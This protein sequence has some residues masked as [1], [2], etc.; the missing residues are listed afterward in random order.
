MRS[1]SFNL[2]EVQK[3]LPLI[4]LLF[5]LVVTPVIAFNGNGGNVN[6]V[7]DPNAS[8]KNHGQYVSCIAHQH[9]GG[10]VVSQAAK[11]D[12]GKKGAGVSPSP[13]A[14]PSPSPEASPS[15][16]PEISPSPSPEVS[17]SPSPEASPS[18]SPEAEGA[19]VGS[20]DVI[21]QIIALLQ[22][23]VE[24]LNSLL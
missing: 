11:S 9:P 18:P 5:V 19:S 21:A 14:S 3:L 7:C 23:I 1:I 15:P 20:N 22:G 6:E 2:L 10:Q 16:S 12:V 13:S 4:T 24:R 17:P 8:W